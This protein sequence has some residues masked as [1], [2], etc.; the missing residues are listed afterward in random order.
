MWGAILRFRPDRPW[1]P[2]SLLHNGYP[3]SFPGVKRDVD[4]PP[5]TSAEVKERVKLYLYCPSGPSW[6]VLGLTLTLPLP[7]PL[8]ERIQPILKVAA[9]HSSEV[10]RHLT[11]QSF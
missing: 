4:H 3:F 6:P 5:P 2:P 8:R 7:L 9:I 10:T 11:A 1:G